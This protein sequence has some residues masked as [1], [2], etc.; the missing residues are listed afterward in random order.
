MGVRKSTPLP[1]S[2]EQVIDLTDIE[3]TR[4]ILGEGDANLRALRDRLGIQVSAR[5]TRLLL[6]GP[7]HALAQAKA[8]IQALRAIYRRQ[9][10]VESSDILQAITVTEQDIEMPNEGALQLPG[11]GRWATPRTPGQK[12]YLDAIARHD[13][14]LCTG[15]AGSGKTYLAVAAAIHALGQGAVNRIV[16]ARPAV[17]AGEKLGFLPGDMA[18]KVNPYLRPI[19]DALDDLLTPEQSHRYTERGVIEVAPIAFMRGRTLNRSFAILDEAQNCTVAQL[20]MFLT[21]LGN[22]SKAVVTG[23][24]TQSD[25]PGGTSGLVDALQTLQGVPGIAEVALRDCD[26]VRHPLVTRI[27]EAY[28]RRRP[29]TS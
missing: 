28:E 20:K 1:S 6:R 11:K 2:A 5:G 21:R 13:L 29:R 15:P 23:D 12:A 9:G 22:Q 16:L 18:E 26:I 3:E 7:S 25:L 24:V 8:A 14:V 19:Y 17:E 10:R 27:V 4:A